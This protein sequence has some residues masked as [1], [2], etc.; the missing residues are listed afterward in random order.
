MCVLALPLPIGYN[1]PMDTN[2]TRT[3]TAGAY[4]ARAPRI[5]VMG[6]DYLH[7]QLAD[8]S[9][10]YLTEFGLPFGRQLL[11]ENHWSDEAYFMANRVKLRGTSAV[12]RVR[13]KEVD[14][15]AKDIV[16]KWNRMG[17][18]IPG[19]TQTGDLTGAKFNSPFEEFGL[20]LE[21][22]DTAHESP[23]RI[24]TH[25]PMGIYVPRE[26]VEARRMGRKQRLLQGLQDRHDEITLDQNRN[27][28][29]MYEWIKGLDAVQAFEHGYINA[30][31]LRGLITRTDADMRHKGFVVRDAKAHHIIVRPT[32]DDEL[33]RGR[34][35]TL[36][37]AMI[38][39]ELLERTPQR[40][41]ATRASRRQAY[42]HRQAHR[43]E[44]EAELPTGLKRVNILGVD[45]VYGQVG[46][47]DGRLWVVG[48]DPALF[49]YFLPVKWRRTPREVLGD[50]PR[51]YGTT[52]KDNIH[53]TWR[54]SRV[55]IRP[56][57]D[58]AIDA[59]GNA[60]AYGYNSPFEEIALSLELSRQ[61]IAT[62]YPR[63]IYMT[64]RKPEP[65]AA[66]VDFSRYK[67]HERIRTFDD[68]PILCPQHDHFLIWGYW[69]GP[70][71]ALATRDEDV[72]TRIDARTARDRG[73]ITE[74]D[75]GGLMQVTRRRLAEAGLDCLRLHGEHM[76]LS[77]DRTGGLATDDTNMPAVRLCSFE[78]LRRTGATEPP[79][80]TAE[81]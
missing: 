35:G 24:H 8:G 68:H 44:T 26:F 57:V 41:R 55:G 50:S 36:L 33:A 76:L 81:G 40:E 58:P 20:V 75:Y 3:A 69:N 74:A 7:L 53:L 79:T 70:D 9:D 1:A 23:G 43:F 22:R 38:D 31:T 27:Y 28:A 78:L 29:V 10:L 37:Y 19:Q 65:G 4:L 62:T 49:D 63:A 80:I 32:R 18:D 30:D 48:K 14:G 25:K 45:Y 21:L 60:A 39:F 71:E 15:L 54:V 67:T 34:D 52:T 16:L 46:S 64:G 17:Q 73:I 59:E 13:T 2:M 6:V 56:D 72:F 66:V 42:L 5:T 11:P 47:T 61:G 77:L 51:T 12:Y